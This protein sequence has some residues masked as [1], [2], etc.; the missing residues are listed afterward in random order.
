MID[1]NLLISNLT[2]SY[3]HFLQPSRFAEDPLLSTDRLPRSLS[4]GRPGGQV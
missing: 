2:I 1:A 3:A 4:L